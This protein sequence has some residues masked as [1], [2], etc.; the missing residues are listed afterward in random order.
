MLRNTVLAAPAALLLIGCVQTSQK[1]FYISAI[2]TEENKVPCVVMKDD[3]F[4]LDE[5]NEPVLTPA[6]VKV[7]FGGADSVRLGVRAVQVDNDGK[8]VGG[9]REGEVSPFKEDWRA[10]RPEDAKNQLF[11]LLRNRS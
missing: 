8:V 2:D 5:K 10:V 4:Y 3:N 9:L 11:V 1:D 6:T 7:K